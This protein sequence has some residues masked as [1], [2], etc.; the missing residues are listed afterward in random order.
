MKSK[1]FA[2][3]LMLV[4]VA[5]VFL[6]VFLYFQELKLNQENDDF[7][8]YYREFKNTPAQDANYSFSP[9][10]SMYRALRIA[11][12]T[13]GWN[14]T[15]LQGLKVH[16]VLD[17]ISFTKNSSEIGGTR[18]SL[19]SNPVADYSPTYVNENTTLRYVWI[20]N[21]NNSTMPAIHPPGYYLIDASTAEMVLN[22]FQR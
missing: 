12:I 7:S 6:N 1:V 11:L 15:S 5:S 20:I 21:V 9:P 22:L 2:I 17:Y 19:V 8:L 16:V 10:N 14:A 3:V 13:G 18:L 4:L